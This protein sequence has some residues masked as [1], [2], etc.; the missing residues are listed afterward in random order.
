MKKVRIFPEDHKWLNEFHI[1]FPQAVGSQKMRHCIDSKSSHS[2]SKVI[3]T[4]KKK[5]FFFGQIPLREKKK[6]PPQT[7]M[8]LKKI[9]QIPFCHI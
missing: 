8:R 3:K 9:C 2:K 7:I 6:I 4:M 1:G 5:T